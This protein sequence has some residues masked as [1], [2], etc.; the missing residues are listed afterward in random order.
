MFAGNDAHTGCLVVLV[1]WLEHGFP[2]SVQTC[3][4]DHLGASGKELVDI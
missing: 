1:G 4:I 2:T 3:W